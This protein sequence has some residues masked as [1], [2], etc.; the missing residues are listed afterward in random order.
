MSEP[1]WILT[2]A[3]ATFAI[4]IA[5]MMISYIR[6]QHDKKHGVKTAIPRNDIAAE[7]AK[8]NDSGVV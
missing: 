3:M 4:A 5:F 2:L 1:N 8:T 6:T 7:R